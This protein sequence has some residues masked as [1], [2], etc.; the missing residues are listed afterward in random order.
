[1]GLRSLCRSRKKKEFSVSKRHW[2]FALV[3]RQENAERMVETDAKVTAEIEMR[4]ASVVF[5]LQQFDRFQ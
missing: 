5:C 1:M 2:F 3:Y 4:L